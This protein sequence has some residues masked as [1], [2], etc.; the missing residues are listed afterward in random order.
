[1]RILGVDP[2]SLITGYGLIEVD[3]PRVRALEYGVLRTTRGT[4]LSKR[5][6]TIYE[7]LLDILRRGEPGVV[8][9]EDVFYQKNFKSAVT[10]GEV[11]AV[12]ILAA[13]SRN[14][15]VRGYPPARV[16]QAIVGNGR[17]VKQQV[18]AMVSRLLGLKETPAEDAAD[19]LA[20]AIC[21]SHSLNNSLNVQLR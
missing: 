19:A 9:V 11:R 5:L 18:Q 17:A 2:G 15:E 6:A 3:G 20:I 12:A 10:I 13:A 16:K 4:Q 8:V 21:H 14:T 1:M 7:G